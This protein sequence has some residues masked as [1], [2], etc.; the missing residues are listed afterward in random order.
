MFSQLVSGRESSPILVPSHTPSP[1]PE[2]RD[3]GTLRRELASATLTMREGVLS[4]ICNTSRDH[5]DQIYPAIRFLLSN[6]L[7]L[8][9]SEEEKLDED[10]DAA[11]ADWYLPARA[12]LWHRYGDSD[13]ESRSQYALAHLF[14]AYAYTWGVNPEGDFRATLKHL[15][16]EFDARAGFP[17]YVFSSPLFEELVFDPDKSL[18][19]ELLTALS[20]HALINTRVYIV[21]EFQLSW[22]RVMKRLRTSGSGRGRPLAG[23]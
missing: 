4:L 6:Q 13:I 12:E 15:H 14:P 17:P 19:D 22:L 11:P 5:I 9:L 2:D 18:I 10:E 20:S 7:R 8:P 16:S 21:S 3:I 23:D 1:I